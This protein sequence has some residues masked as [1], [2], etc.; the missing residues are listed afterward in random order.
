[1]FGEDD[2]R[3]EIPKTDKEAEGNCW[4]DVVGNLESILIFM[5]YFV[6]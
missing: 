1:V 5:D 4:A 3:D 2:A 6:D